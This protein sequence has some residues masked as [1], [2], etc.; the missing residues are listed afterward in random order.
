MLFILIILG[1][2]VAISALVVI[3][4]WDSEDSSDAWVYGI[5][6]MGVSGLVS[7]I[8]F[9]II[10]GFSYDSYVDSRTFYDITREQYASAIVIYKDAA[11]I[12]MGKAAFTDLKYNGYQ[13]NVASFIRD[14]RRRIIKYNT[15]VQSK[16]IM[17]RNI[18][19]SWLIVSP[20][21]D[22]KLIRMKTEVETVQ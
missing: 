12:D 6:S 16:R 7:G 1:I 9:L 20:D 14:L 13:D 19:F 18:F 4:N 10:W 17:K 15:T 22:M 8:M 5:V 21:D 11:V 3:G 2:G